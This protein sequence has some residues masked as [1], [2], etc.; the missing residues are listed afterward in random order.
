MTMAKIGFVP[1]E[2]PSEQPQ[3]IPLYADNPNAVPGWWDDD[4]D[5]EDEYRD[6]N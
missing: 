1:D 3:I 4:E 2:D 5:D 6:Y